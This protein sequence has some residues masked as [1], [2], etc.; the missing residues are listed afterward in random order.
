MI[1]NVQVEHFLPMSSLVDVNWLRTMMV[2]ATLALWF[3]AT[4][5][6]RLESIPGLEFLRCASDANN[7]SDCDGDGCET[8]EKGFYKIENDRPIVPAPILVVVLSLPPLL[9]ETSPAGL[10]SGGESTSAPPELP[11]V[12]QFSLR[13]A[14][15]PRAPS[16]A[17]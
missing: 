16:I 9:T 17:S 4:N 13:T 3:P 10:V 12:W 7:G 14:L 1:R 11:K 5:H 8:V 2:L 6:C 15:P